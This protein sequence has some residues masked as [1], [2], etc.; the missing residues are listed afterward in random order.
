[1][2]S[3]RLLPTTGVKCNK[4]YDSM[5]ICWLLVLLFVATRLVVAEDNDGRC[6]FWVDMN[7]GEP[8]PY[9][10]ILED[11]AGVRVIYLGECHRLERHHQIQA[12]ILTDLAQRGLPLVLGLEQ[13]E[14]FQQ[15]TLD[16]YNK[17]EI[18]FDQLVQATRWSERWPNCR[19]YR[20]ILESAR[21]FGVPI[22]A[23]NAR[24]ETIR[25]VARSGGIDKMNP[26]A[27]KELP[28]DIQ[29]EDP[30]YEQLLNLRMMVHIVATPER[31]RPMFEAQISRDEMMASVLC[32][33]LRSQ[34]GQGRTAIVLCGSGHVSY[35]LG[36][37][38]RVRRRL[39]GVKDRI[40]L[41][42][43]SGDVK[44][45]TREQA[46][47]REI[48]ITHEQLRNIDKPIADYLHATSLKQKPIPQSK[49]KEKKKCH[50][51]ESVRSPS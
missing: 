12:Q 8:V 22:L 49:K 38:A 23:L 44:L 26:Q 33:F 35:G 34:R 48:N 40:I 6:S 14:S 43:E 11:L 36:M 24:K 47:A 4:R 9:E 17:G 27:R 37:P 20:P 5:K 50:T 45:S 29:R 3:V 7:R 19:Q 13:M 51:K 28:P 16:R 39:P 15:S 42:S 46:M 2:N 10:D 41:L 32:S 25:Q 1:M 18:D 31:L 21:K 30:L